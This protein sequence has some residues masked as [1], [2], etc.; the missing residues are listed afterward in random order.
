MPSTRVLLLG[1]GN[2]WASD[3]GVG[4]EVARQVQ[5]WLESATNEDVLPTTIEFC[6]APQPDLTWLDRIGQ[7]QRLII[8]DAVVSAAHPA[9][10]IHRQTWKEAALGEK[11]LA[12]A[13]SHGF[14]VRELLRMAEALG[15][16]PDQVDLWGVEAAS[17]APGRGL[18]QPVARAAA[19]IAQEIQESLTT[20]Q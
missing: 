14:G 11:D 5:A 9:G 19:R 1:V 15:R 7:A 2:E 10:T 3:D 20:R 17:L 4:P 8:V 13:S 18:S 6:I 16:L 12:R